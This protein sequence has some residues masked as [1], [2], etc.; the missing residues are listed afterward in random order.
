[1][2]EV[3]LARKAK[4]A[5]NTVWAASP[6]PKPSLPKVRAAVLL[7]SGGL[8]LELD[9]AVAAEWMCN[10]ANRASVLA[11]IG[12]GASIKNR[13]YQVIVQFIPVQ[14]DPNNDEMHRQFE[15]ANDLQ[16]NS[17]LKMEWIKP[18][19]DRRE[20][21]WVAMARFYLKDAKSANIILSKGAYVFGRKVV[22][23]KPSREPIRCLKCQLFGHERQHCVSTEPRCARCAMNHETEDCGGQ[24]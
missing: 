10:D 14:F 21:Q 7:R 20:S 3:V 16:P 19:K 18:I 4:D 24:L 5:I 12:S 11:N 13:S 17:V 8:L 6:E 15:E 23:K 9:S 22:P 2:S 1:M